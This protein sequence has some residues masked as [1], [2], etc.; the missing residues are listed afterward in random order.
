MIASIDFSTLLNTIIK[1]IVSSLQ[2]KDIESEE[3]RVIDTAI[4][5]FV[6]CLLHNNALITT[7]FSLPEHIIQDDFTVRGL[8]CPQTII[9]RKAF[10]QAILQV[11]LHVKHPSRPPLPYFLAV[12]LQKMPGEA[13]QLSQGDYTQYFELLCNL[14][15]NDL[16]TSDLDYEALAGDLLRKILSFPSNERRN[17]AVS[18]RVFVGYLQ[19]AEKLY[20]KLPQLRADAFL[21]EGFSQLLFPPLRDYSGLTYEECLG[22]RLDEAAPKCKG[23]ESRAAAY[24]LFVTLAAGQSDTLSSLAECLDSATRGLEIPTTWSNSPSTETRSSLG[25][26]GIVNI[27]NVCY[28]NSILQQFFMIPQLRYSILGI[29]DHLPPTNVAEPKDWTE[30]VDDNILHQL[31]RLFGALELTE[32]QAYNPR[33]FYFS[34]KDYESKPLNTAI[35]ADASEFLNLILDRLETALK[36]TAQSKLLQGVLGGKTC[37]QMICKECTTVLERQEDFFSLSLDVK[38]SRSLEQS[39]E[40]LIA[41]DIISDFMCETCHKK[42]DIVKH[43]LLKDLPNVLVIHLQRIVFN[44][45][46]FGN[47]KI[48]SRLEFPTLLDLKKFTKQ[49]LEAKEDEV[50]HPEEFSYELIGIVVHTGTAD[51]GHY[52][53]YCRQRKPDGTAD[54]SKWIELNDSTVKSFDQDKMESECYG[55]VAEDDSSWVK[56]ENNKN[57]YVLVYERKLKTPLVVGDEQRHFGDLRKTLPPAVFQEVSADNDKFLRERHLYNTEFFKFLEQLLNAAAAVS[58]D[59]TELGT[60]LALTVAA[61]T[62]HNSKALP[63]LVKALMADYETSQQACENRLQL[64]LDSSLLELASLLLNPSEAATRRSVSELLLFVINQAILMDFSATSKARRVLDS[65]LELVATEVPKNWMRFEQYW[66]FFNNFAKSGVRQVEFLFEID[67]PALLADFFLGSKSPL[68]KPGVVRPTVGSK[69]AK[70]EFSPLIQTLSTLVAFAATD[71]D[72]QGFKLSDDAMKVLKSKEFYAKCLSCAYDCDALGKIAAKL[73]YNDAATTMMLTELI[74]NELNRVDY[75]DIKPYFQMI[76]HLLTIEDDLTVGRFENLL[77]VPT[78]Y[79]MKRLDADL[80]FYGS[81]VI[82]AIDDD[83][84]VYRSPCNKATNAYD[85]CDC[86]LQLLWKHRNR[87]ENYAALGLKYLLQFCTENAALKGYIQAV[88][89]PNYQ[90]SR[91]TDW[92]LPFAMH[93]ATSGSTW[94]YAGLPKREDLTKELQE[95]Y[96]KVIDWL[97]PQPTRYILGKATDRRTVMEFEEEE[98]SVKVYVV[99]TLWVESKPDGKVNQAIPGKVTRAELYPPSMSAVPNKKPSSLGDV[100]MKNYDDLDIDAAYDNFDYSKLDIFAEA[101]Y[102]ADAAPPPVKEEHHEA[103]RAHKPVVVEPVEFSHEDETLVWIEARNRGD[104]EALVEVQVSPGNAWTPKSELLIGLGVSSVKDLTFE[105]RNFAEDFS[106]LHFQVRLLRR[107]VEEAVEPSSQPSDFSTLTMND[108]IAADDELDVPA[109]FKPCPA[110]TLFNPAQCFRCDA[111]GHLF[112]V[113]TNI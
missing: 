90:F 41:D 60:R 8:T 113:S 19:L 105:K 38:H 102:K 87:Y 36:P 6:S 65:L 25:Y 13:G 11:C 66:D 58:L 54:P 59:I 43:T 2:V 30:A 81:S 56:Y 99:K 64:I 106:S 107:V 73:S 1:I 103:P 33:Q 15:D 83:V 53:S 86:L 7:F 76:R 88:L 14:V 96:C 89:P 16:G 100:E 69:V 40:R 37:S 21:I 48:N 10:A 62:A 52:Y 97:A 68:H 112:T 5:L 23:R 94:V 82:S 17:S 39:L 74:L 12:L 26:A 9:V 84:V 92:V 34:C 67:A 63:E 51:S 22:S 45:D 28:A 85:H 18:D 72:D 50:V 20:A 29:D 77:G 55:G 31:Q 75:E 101:T 71:P 24:K 104:Q 80:P 46:T 93:Y 70:A 110:C 47:E 3:R 35:Q 108:L 44:F 79:S 57:A 32:R 98:V 42:V 111:C 78:V 91:Y 4:E 109:G 49:G 95:L 61:R 27:G